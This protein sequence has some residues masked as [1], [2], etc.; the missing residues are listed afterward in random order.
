MVVVRGGGEGES[1][2]PLLPRRGVGTG[3]ICNRLC[4]L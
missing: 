2:G 1:G 4:D 3:W